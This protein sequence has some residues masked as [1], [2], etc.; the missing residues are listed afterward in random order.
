MTRRITFAG[1]AIFL[2]LPTLSLAQSELGTWKLNT[3]KSNSTGNAMPKSRTITIETRGDGFMTHAEGI[4]GDGTPVNYSYTVKYDGKD[5][6]VTGAGTPNGADT[7][8]SKRIDANTA[9]STW[10]KGGKVV[11]TARRSISNDGKT[12]T[13]TASG[14][15]PD[16]KATSA[17]SVYDKQ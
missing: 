15:R 2:A 16:G 10:K 14:T 4:A 8:T 11:N 17:R 7:I 12:M 1:L 5:Y 9:E 6:P 3:A 13:S